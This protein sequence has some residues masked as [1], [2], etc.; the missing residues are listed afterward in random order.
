MPS[1]R[2]FLR[3]AGAGL[4]LTASLGSALIPK[5]LEGQGS[6]ASNSSTSLPPSITALKSMKGE[7]KPITV[8]ERRARIEHAR[9]LMAERRIDALM[10][11]SGASLVYF[12]N[13][14]WW[15]GERLFA[16]ILPAKGR[17]FFVCPA[18]E[19]DRAE[20][21]IA[22]SPFASTSGIAWATAW[23][24]TGTSGRTWCVEIP[25]SWS[26]T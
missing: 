8:E 13:I 1:R 12:S 25:S 26:Q 16:L 10:L 11:I 19:R 14:R 2:S 20:E 17:P 3:D 6:G 7:A 22:L 4:A 5:P 24:W 9:R 18:F 15:G 23:G 21:Q